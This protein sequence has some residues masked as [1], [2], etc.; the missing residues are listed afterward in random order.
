MDAPLHDIVI[1]SDFHI[2]RGKN[3][4]SGRY[5]ELEAFFYDDDF[6]S[7]CRRLVDE[8]QARGEPFTLV[9]N[10]D[11]FDLL[12]IERDVDSG[13]STTRGRR[14]GPA[15]TP[16]LASSLMAEI[17]EGHP[18]F[19]DAIALVLAAGNTVVLL[20][21]NHDLE[22]Q[23][24]SVQAELRWAILS[25]VA[26]NMSPKTD[27]DAR[28]EELAEAAAASDEAG[29]RLR[30]LP[31]FYHEPGRVWI[32]HGCQYDPENAFRYLLRG[33]LDDR[34]DSISEAE[35]DMPLGNFFQRYLYNAFGH[36]TFIVPS[37]RAN[38]RY[39]KWLALNK[40]RLLLRVVLSH[41]RFWW[42]VVRRV[43]APKTHARRALKTTHEKALARLADESGLGDR[44]HQIEAL[45]AVRGDIH[46][47]VRSL[48]WQ[49]LRVLTA[50]LVLALATFGLWFAGFHGINQLRAGF[51]F[52]AS[53]FLL[54]DFF[55]L[56]VGM[57]GLGYAVLRTAHEPSSRPLRRAAAKIAALVDVPIVSFGHTHEEVLWRLEL[58][59]GAW[60]YNTGTWIAVFTHD[61]LIPRDRVQY[62][63]LRI[64]G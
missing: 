41:A 38:L 3:P 58:D 51:V 14:F 2:G 63:F 36:I 50:A 30:F 12:R 47:A 39:F 44:L 7:F 37:T 61:V 59:R 57:A 23:W 40:P 31:W 13:A 54:L 10:G 60:Y 11:T 35:Q 4:K 33:E 9:F 34:E 6:L 27:P 46:Q 21:G 62:T 20:P 48:G 49:S 8:A 45:K 55:F 26:Q 22:I 28:A 64:S 32:E 25:R 17:V 42:H 56:L 19:F 16:T 43:T 1:V 53:L 15:M 5:Y 24:P 18:I 52:K 29:A